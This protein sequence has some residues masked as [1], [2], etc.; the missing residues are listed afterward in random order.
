MPS[1]L[2]LSSSFM[3][4][5]E[6]PALPLFPSIC[7]CTLR[8]HRKSRACLSMPPHEREGLTRPA[9]SSS[10]ARSPHASH[11]LQHSTPTV[12]RA[13]LSLR[14]F[15]YPFPALF[16]THVSVR[17]LPCA[18]FA[19]TEKAGLAYRCLPMS[20]KG[21]R[22]QPQVFPSSRPL[23]TKHGAFLRMANRVKTENQQ[24]LRFCNELVSLNELPNNSRH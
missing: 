9:P 24:V 14:R 18:P 23:G 8:A 22:A 5:L 1:Y 6:S 3:H 21:S 7:P 15:P 2:L 4:Y 13:L 12:L 19:L 11:N 17:I 16:T 20:A 10:L